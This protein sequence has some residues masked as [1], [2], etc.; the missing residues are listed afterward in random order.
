VTWVAEENAPDGEFIVRGEGED[1]RA[2]AELR[3][4]V[5]GPQVLTAH[6]L[7]QTASSRSFTFT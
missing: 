2:I 3:R 1:G 5:R 6:E 4:G 7:V